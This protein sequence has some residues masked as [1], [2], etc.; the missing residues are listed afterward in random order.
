MS[1]FS[2]LE[3]SSTIKGEIGYFGLSEW[4]LSEFSKEERIYIINTFQPLGSPGDISLV[5]GEI[6][7]MNQSPTDFLSTLSGWFRKEQDR[8]IAYRLLKKAEELINDSSK[9]LDLHFLYMYKLKLYYKDRDNNP[10]ALEKAI[11]ACKQQINIAPKA[12]NAFKREDMKSGIKDSSLPNHSG[13]EQ[14][15]II[16]EK[17]KNFESAIEISK[18]AMKQGWAGDWEKRIERCKK[19]LDKI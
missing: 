2:F 18:K 5:K 1:I 16:E 4:W 10:N 13:F 17:K 8:T 14:L 9:V 12:M 3:N 19:K 6:F 7:G 15:A 11:E